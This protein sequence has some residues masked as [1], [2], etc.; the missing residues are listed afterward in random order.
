VQKTSTKPSKSE[1]RGIALKQMALLGRTTIPYAAAFIGVHRYTLREYIDRG[2]LLPIYVG[3]R[4][5]LTREELIRFER[6]GK[7]VQTE[8]AIPEEFQS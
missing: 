7:T 2:Y 8:H 3:K 4:P 6:E 5:W 1:A